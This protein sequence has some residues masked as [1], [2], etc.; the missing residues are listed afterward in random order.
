MDV[1]YGISK[2]HI[3]LSQETCKDFF[4]FCIVYLLVSIT[5]FI[6]HFQ[7]ERDF[8]TYLTA[9]SRALRVGCHIVRINVQPSSL[10]SLTTVQLYRCGGTGWDTGLLCHSN[11]TVVITY[12]RSAPGS[13]WKGKALSPHK[14]KR[15]KGKCCFSIIMALVYRLRGITCSCSLHRAIPLLMQRHLTGQL[16]CLRVTCYQF[17]QVWRKA[18]KS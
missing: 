5:W 10:P 17:L 1:N 4:F 3:R 14:G 7:S 6:P 18:T 12:P 15:C 2:F 16:C 9:D 8:C 13:I 11:R